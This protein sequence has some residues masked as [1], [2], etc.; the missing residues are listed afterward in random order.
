MQLTLC[1]MS[2]ICCNV[3]LKCFMVKT[4]LHKIKHF[5]H[6][7]QNRKISSRKSFIVKRNDGNSAFLFLSGVIAS[8][9]IHPASVSRR[10]GWAGINLA[11][12]SWRL[13]GISWCPTCSIDGHPTCVGGLRIS[14][15][16]FLFLVHISPSSV[17]VFWFEFSGFPPC[18]IGCTICTN[19]FPSSVDGFKISEDGFSF[20]RND[21]RF[22]RK[23]LLTFWP[24]LLAFRL[25]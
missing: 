10:L 24:N 19:G 21:G 5:R 17:N 12:V 16:R 7:L 22:P 11:G 4:L 2:W 18:V 23:S 20:G 1:Q 8:V 13:E 25:T 15:N 9:R 14:A 6:C 3:Q